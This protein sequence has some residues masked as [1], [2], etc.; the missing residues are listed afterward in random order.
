MYSVTVGFLSKDLKA[1]LIKLQEGKGNTSK[2]IKQETTGMLWMI[3]LLWSTSCQ[4]SLILP[5]KVKDLLLHT[6]LD[7]FQFSYHLLVIWSI[8]LED[9]LLFKKESNSY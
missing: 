9:A 5:L 1:H 3:L 2:K 7:T 4:W 6:I 8:N